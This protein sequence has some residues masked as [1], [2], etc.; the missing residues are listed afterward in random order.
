MIPE[1]VRNFEGAR[2][3]SGNDVVRGTTGANSL[4]GG[5]GKDE[6][7]GLAGN[8]WLDGESGDD[9]LNGGT[10][11]DFIFG[12][13]GY[14]IASYADDIAGV[15]VDL[16]VVGIQNTFGSGNDLLQSIEGLIGSAVQRLAVRQWRR[17]PAD[18]RGGEDQMFGRD[19]AD[20]LIGGD[21]NDNLFGGLGND[22]LSGGNGTDWANYS[23]EASG[24]NINLTTENAQNTLGAGFDTLISIENVIGTASADLLI[25]NTGGNRLEGGGG[26]DVLTAAPAATCC[27]AGPATTTSTAAPATTCWRAAPASTGRSTTP[28]S[29][30]ASRS[31]STPTIQIT[32]GGGVDTLHD[33]ENVWATS[34]ADSL[35]GNDFANELRGEGG[36]DWIWGNGGNDVVNGGDG[37]D[38]VAGG[39][40]ADDVIGGVGNDHLW[41][42]T[43]ADDFI[44]AQQL[45]RRLDLGLPVRLRQ[46]RPVRCRR[47]EQHQPARRR[48]HR[49]RRALHLRLAARSCWSASH[50][51]RPHHG[52][53]PLIRGA[54]DGTPA[55]GS[56]TAQ[57]PAIRLLLQL[58]PTQ[59]CSLSSVIGRSRTRF[60]VA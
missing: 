7:R 9:V 5:A 28:G 37:N 41:G 33:I 12:G 14:D 2:M 48:E 34:F 4:Y 30:P 32:G 59:R 49:R 35:T 47:V 58:R 26:N 11:D 18:R 56:R 57:A 50:P 27:S 36:N 55:P 31:T 52:F 42:G 17:Q 3:G 60:P 19:G 8:D 43:N 20:I 24:V 44:F 6:L 22:V 54:M 25:G 15:L 16:N 1:L 51:L 39:A 40:G 53:H 45:G 46:D 10:G 21:G 38:A 13:S 23:L 29:P